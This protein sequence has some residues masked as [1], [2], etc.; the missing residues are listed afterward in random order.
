MARLTNCDRKQIVKEMTKTISLRSRSIEKEIGLFLNNRIKETIPKDVF[1]FCKKWTKLI[2][3]TK[4]IYYGGVSGCRSTYFNVIEHP[5]AFF[6]NHSGGILQ[7]FK[8]DIEHGD[9]L[10]NLLT[11]F[12]NTC[13]EEKILINKIICALE[14]ISTEKKLKEEFPEVYAAY[15]KVPTET[16]NSCDAIEKVRAELS[17]YKKE[18]K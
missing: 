6:S 11:S 13:K 17:N 15:T 2:S 7:F 8:E 14:S 4:T 16:D 18:K 9:E 5:S 10:K 1:D 3:T 12:D